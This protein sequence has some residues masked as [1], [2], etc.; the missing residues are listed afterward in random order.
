MPVASCKVITQQQIVLLI[1]TPSTLAGSVQWE[2]WVRFDFASPASSLN[3]ADVYLTASAS[4][5][6][7]SNTTGYVVR[8]GNTDRE[9]A[10]YR[11]DGTEC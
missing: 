6:S 3:F 8:I 11:K 10:L 5:L 9:V 2:F 7:L 1:S 4:D